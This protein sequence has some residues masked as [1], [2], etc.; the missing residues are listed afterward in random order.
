M[1]LLEM[2]ERRKLPVWR[3]VRLCY[4]TVLQNLGQLA[5]ISWLWLLIMVPVYTAVHWLPSADWEALGIRT[6]PLWAR[7]M[8][9]SLPP[10]VELPFLAS[11]A[12][13]WHR[14]VLRQ[15]RVLAP[16]YLRLDTPV[17]LYALC[18]LGFLTLMVGPVLG[19]LT[20]VEQP[21]SG[22]PHLD[23][24]IHSLVTVLGLLALTLAVAIFLLPRLS[25]VLPA[26]A[27]GERLSLWDAWRATRG[28]T[29]RLALATALCMLPALFLIMSLP[30]LAVLLS[31]LSSESTPM[32]ELITSLNAIDQ[33]VGSITYAVF[34]SLAYA[35]LTIFAVTLL[36]LAYQALIA[37]R[38]DS[39]LPA[40]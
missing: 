4:A 38:R 28:N 11:I 20:F 36:S 15:E 17:W 9:V 21:S 26:L 34:N 16:T 39:G 22:P 7:Q 10:I 3:T 8:V 32:Q 12:V 40:A 30:L 23:R 19:A 27:L 25:L 29:L 35:I 18:S 1:T 24:E 2:S 6:I 31:A 5:R 37:Q 33:I 13:A 14:L